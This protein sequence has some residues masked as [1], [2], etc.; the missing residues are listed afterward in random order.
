M[1]VRGLQKIP[2][3]TNNMN[4]F[5]NGNAKCRFGQVIVD[6]SNV[7]RDG[8][9][10][11]CRSP[12]SNLNGDSISPVTI[13]ISLTGNSDS[14]VASGSMFVYDELVN[15][16]EIIPSAGS[17]FGG[18]HVEIFG[19]PFPPSS[20]VRCR[21]G[22]NIVEGDWESEDKVICP[23]PP[24][25]SIDEVQKVEVFSMAWNPE[26]QSIHMTV[27]DFVSEIHEIRTSGANKPVGEIQ[28]IRI[29][30]EDDRDEVQKVATKIDK[31]NYVTIS[32][33]FSE[34]YV[35]KV[36]RKIIFSAVDSEEIY[37]GT[38]NIC[39]TATNFNIECS[40]PIPL[41]VNASNLEKRIAVLSPKLKE[42]NIYEENPNART[43]SKSY[44]LLCSLDC[45]LEH[46][47]VNIPVLNGM[48][49]K[50]DLLNNEYLDYSEV[51]KISLES[52]SAIYGY[53]T[54]TFNDVS[55][56]KISWN[57]TETDIQ[58]ELRKIT[59]IGKVNVTRE[60]VIKKMPG[61][62]KESYG[63]EDEYQ[64]HISFLAYVWSVTFLT[65][66]GEIPNLIVCC[67]SSS[68]KK[69]T[70]FP[71]YSDNV[72]L[73][74]I[75]TFRNSKY[76]IKG[77]F[78]VI[79]NNFM[80]GTE[81]SDPIPIDANETLV[82]QKIRQMKSIEMDSISVLHDESVLNGKISKYVIKF[83][84]LDVNTYTSDE[85][86]L[87]RLPSVEVKSSLNGKNVALTHVNIDHNFL[88]REIQMLKINGDTETITCNDGYGQGEFSFAFSSTSQTLVEVMESISDNNS[89]FPIYGKVSVS[90][91][92]FSSRSIGWKITF[93]EQI[94]DVPELDCRP[95]AETYTL[96]NGTGEAINDGDFKL[97][98]GPEQ[99]VTISHNGT[100]EDVRDALN[101][102]LGEGA[103][104]VS[105]ENNGLPN[106][107]GERSW[108]ITFIGSKRRGNIDKVLVDGSNLQ[109][110]SAFVEV[111]EITAGTHLKGSFRIG[112]VEEEM[113]KPISIMGDI[114][115]IRYALKAIPGF[116]DV[117]VKVEETAFGGKNYLFE[118]PHY[119]GEPPNGMIPPLSGNLPLIN[120][121]CSTL[122]GASFQCDTMTVRNGTNPVSDDEERRGFRIV[123]PG[124][125]TEYPLSLHTEWLHF[126]ESAEGMLNALQSTGALPIDSKI[127]REG[128][129][130][131]GGKWNLKSFNDS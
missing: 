40:G 13:D 130:E 23:S 73:K 26:I 24:L 121:D 108:L 93:L 65:H 10:V 62:K 102:V 46:L 50:I 7:T 117:G 101:G 119:I 98:V 71:K 114:D 38:F 125:S 44:T 51:Q 89:I 28:L 55:T 82:I 22:D 67:D 61:I 66:T 35:P 57:A 4:I 124:G 115:D 104:T 116:N 32:V 20:S 3:E 58:N 6:A 85:I 79:M 112:I 74:V 86:S 72:R 42:L 69:Q 84:P 49:T 9:E 99:S 106:F 80:P 11:W 122:L 59:Q 8:S 5:I 48:T 111:E 103:V 118:F 18:R 100:K 123:A 81:K 68:L 120:V 77:H 97:T 63:K 91:H 2:F 109:G 78:Q 19:G 92:T 76:D 70:I 1:K 12:P 83:K 36:Q 34:K 96:L 15:I 87:N 127:L 25:G 33:G 105:D 21:F 47:S 41:D 110:T 17:V 29:I 131:D 16:A 53:F 64:G 37:Y 27:D 31:S 113:S 30:A 88:R 95:F 129:Y 52:S 39:F 128:P 94:G 126:N 75:K 107:N 14:F 45:D 54:L 43:G 60:T 90:R 56:S